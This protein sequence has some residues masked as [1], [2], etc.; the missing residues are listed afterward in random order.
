MEEKRPAHS[1]RKPIVHTVGQPGMNRWLDTGLGRIPPQSIE[2]EE[3]VLGAIMLENNMLSEVIEIL[4]PDSFYR[5][6]HQKIYHAILTLFNRSE[7]V[8]MLTVTQRLRNDGTLEMAGGPPYLAGLTG[9][10]SSS[11]NVVAYARKIAENA[12][13]RSLIQTSSEV[14][15]EAYEDTTDVF[16]LLDK[17]EQT[18]FN[19]S[20]SNI[21]RN[22]LDMNSVVKQ[23]LDE[24]E[25]KKN[26]KDGLTG[27]GA[28]P[29]TNILRGRSRPSTR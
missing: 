3:A 15:N 10:I 14:L 8:D 24:L 29:T 5:E 17:A 20:E 7:P 12:I 25:S 21:R 26:L 6:A 11:A 18:L 27:A 16:E 28:F 2:L 9:R 19:I 22:F 23:A 1:L 4:Q 13:K